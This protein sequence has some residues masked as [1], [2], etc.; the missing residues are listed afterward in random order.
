MTNNAFYYYFKLVKFFSKKKKIYLFLF[1]FLSLL[2]SLTEILSIG[3]LVPFI[4]LLINPDK[5]YENNIF[6]YFIYNF[7]LDFSNLVLIL[8]IVFVSLITISTL[9]KILY[10]RLNSYLSY[11]IIKDITNLLFNKIINKSYYNLLK[12]NSKDISTTIVL[13]CQ[14]VGET[15]Y[16]FISGVGSLLIIFFLLLN[17]LYFISYKFIY[18]IFPLFLL[19]VIFFL[20]IKKN[21]SKY[22]KTVSDNFANITK[23]IQQVIKFHPE[24]ILYKLNNF[25]FRDF[26]KDNYNLRKAQEGQTF[27]S[28]YP[29][30]IIQNFVIIILILLIYYLYSENILKDKFPLLVLLFFSIQRIM[31]NLQNIFQSLTVISFQKD[32]L[33]KTL[34]ILEQN[35]NDNKN[36]NSFI[37]NNFDSI[38]FKNID[39][40]YEKN[41]T[42]LNNINFRINKNDIVAII[43]ESGAGKT[44]LVKII[45]GFLKPTKGKILLNNKVLNEDFVKFWQLNIAYL[46]QQ[47]FILDESLLANIALSKNISSLEKKNIYSILK[48]LDLNYKDINNVN[49][50]FT[51]KVGE[52]GKFFSGGQI[53]RIGIARAIFQKREFLI[54]DE[55]LNALD[56][57]NFNLVINFLKKIDNITILIISHEKKVINICNKI[58]EIKKGRIYESTKIK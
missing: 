17:I 28:S 12:L 2:T 25:F 29:S 33:K 6:N 7:N 20:F 34:E 21:I 8:F 53:Q 9:L 24:I 56:D 36:D 16:F 19:Y 37:K 45:L 22:S 32:M 54:L 57:K 27:V 5:I 15:N 47:I 55:S 44:T 11:G 10:I 43:G 18:I 50:K 58:L 14:S 35:Q 51:A 52:D 39:F 38:V 42:I 48:K 46:P 41:K 4:T 26:N 31:P 23:N 40:E 49:N 13:R 30:V 1:F 3:S